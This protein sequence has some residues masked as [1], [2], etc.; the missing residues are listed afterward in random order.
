VNVPVA[1][2]PA[3]ED[4]GAPSFRML[5]R[6]TMTP[7]HYKRVNEEGEEVPWEDI[8]KGYERERGKFVVLTEEEIKE[9]R[10]ETSDTIEIDGFV[11]AA[12]ISPLFYEK[13]YYL[14]PL[15]KAEKSY[16]LL[17]E[18]LRA[19]GKVGIA[20]IVIRAREHLAVL[21]V[22]GPLL[23]LNVLRYASELR[24]AS[25]LDVPAEDVRKLGIGKREIEMA[26][27]LVETMEE[28][29][30]PEKYH[31]AYRAELMKRIAKK[32]GR[33]ETKTI[34]EAERAAE[35]GAE[36]VDIMDLLKRSVRRAEGS[37]GR[38]SAKRAAAS[39]EATPRREPRRRRASAARR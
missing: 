30:E 22:E 28:A 9:A 32:I 31:D 33:G 19:T 18:A 4:Q 14:E 3:A 24:D 6:R 11:E 15:P 29:W 7:I 1:L 39:D 25:R 36:V 35:P 21:R 27:R 38:R 16:A 8:V 17:R 12:S 20:S 13:P 34:E 5:D 26:E 10:A 2:H 23:V 37:E